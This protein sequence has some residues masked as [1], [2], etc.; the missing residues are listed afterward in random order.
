MVGQ[1]N[2][3]SPDDRPPTYDGR[4]QR[5]ERRGFG[6]LAG[7]PIVK[8]SLVAILLLGVIAAAG[9]WLYLQSLYRGIP[10]LPTNEQLWA[11]G[12]E[13]AIEFVDTEGVTIAIR[14]PRYGRAVNMET[15]PPHVAQ[16]FIAAEDKRFYEHNGADTRAIIRAFWANL[17]SGE[18]V[19]GASTITQ[20]LIKNLVLTPEQTLKRKA[21]EVRL[22]RELEKRL[23]KDE[24]LELYLN[25]VYFGAGFYGLGAASRFYFGKTPEELTIGEA[26]LLA[27]LPQAP[28]RLALTNNMS[29]A[30]ARQ[31]YVLREMVDA[32]FIT[33]QQSETAAAEQVELAEA[34]E[35]DPQFGYALDAATQ[36]INQILPTLPGDLVVTLTIDSEI[37]EKIDDAFAT[38]MAE[39]GSKQKA[40]QAAGM[41]MDKQGRI[42]AM[43]GGVDYNEN[44]FNRAT[45]ARRQPGSSFKP[46][47]YATA[48]R[49]GLTP[50]DVRNDRRTTIDGWSPQN[51][52]RVYSGPMTLSEALKDSIN[53]VAAQLGEEVGQ[54]NIISLIKS[55]GVSGDFEPFPS[56]ALGS[57]GMSLQDMVRAY[58]VFM[59]GGTR[60][61]PYIIERISNSR[62][63][64]LY[65]RP[66]YEPARVYDRRDAETMVAMMERVV[67][68]GTGKRARL[69]GWDVAGKTGTSQSF[70]D[71]WFV[72]FTS[73]LV[74]GVWV[75]NDDDTAMSRVTGGGLPASLWHDMMEIAHED[76]EP[77]P[78]AG[79]GTLVTL[80]PATQ[81]RISFYRDVGTAFAGVAGD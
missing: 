33:R 62:G 67:T 49:Q 46:F 42:L 25:R 35:R 78:L 48:I 75:G 40:T 45:Q 20:Q 27:T 80:S 77:T 51:Y 56:I 55:F 11:K 32:G 66:Q 76:R 9:G 21:Q 53:T 44:Q 69:D 37:Q 68:D 6:F 14:G 54:E 47:V 34:P 65:E 22:A 59:T 1:N 2:F 57:Q 61:D 24:I 43:Y 28:S 38:R 70:R 30:K 12:R 18:T 5:P 72:G 39:E 74:G 26:S 63:D 16:A 23:S 29:D 60:L 15:L 4:D 79:A 19:S 73:Q 58:G 41:L 8:Y 64:V 50:Y 81:R 3:G 13:Q 31:A 36:R 52:S 10:A 7:R 71:A 17:T